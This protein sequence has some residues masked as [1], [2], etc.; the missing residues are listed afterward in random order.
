[1]PNTAKDSQVDMTCAIS[2][3]NQEQTHDFGNLRD[4]SESS[5]RA[6]DTNDLKCSRI[7]QA[8][9]KLIPLERIQQH[10]VEQIVQ[11]AENED[12]GITVWRML[13]IVVRPQLAASNDADDRD[14][15]AAGVNDTTSEQLTKEC[16]DKG[17]AQGSALYGFRDN[18]GHN[19]TSNRALCESDSTIDKWFASSRRDLREDELESSTLLS[20]RKTVHAAIQSRKPRPSAKSA[21]STS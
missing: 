19:E 13:G 8:V 14:P 12:S 3:P 21:R 17:Q 7:L 11:W 2:S 1:M 16:A 9:V 18:E 4:L 5:G 15:H 6:I 20:H 10:I